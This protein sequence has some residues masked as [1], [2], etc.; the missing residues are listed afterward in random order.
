MRKRTIKI[1]AFF[2]SLIS[3]YVLLFY[4]VEKNLLPD[5]LKFTYLIVA[6]LGIF[7]IPVLLF[8]TFTYELS[9]EFRTI[10]V[11]KFTTAVIKEKHFVVQQRMKNF[12]IPRFSFWITIS[13]EHKE[14]HEADFIVA[15]KYNER[16]KI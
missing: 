13:D 2:V 16:E 11:N 10:P 12:I 7:L 8:F 15:K 1:I 9:D 4:P 6:V 14:K 3:A 5:S